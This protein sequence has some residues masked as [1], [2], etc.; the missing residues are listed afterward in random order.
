MRGRPQY[1]SE[2]DGIFHGAVWEVYEAPRDGRI[3]NMLGTNTIV[4]ERL[5]FGVVVK[6]AA[7]S[8]NHRALSSLRDIGDSDQLV[9]CD[10]CGTVLD[11]E[12][13]DVVEPGSWVMGQI[14]HLSQLPTEDRRDL[15]TETQQLGGELFAMPP[16]VSIS[17]A[18]GFTSCVRV[19]YSMVDRLGAQKGDTVLVTAARSN[20]SMTAIQILTQRGATVTA[21]TSSRRNHDH[22]MK[23]GADEVIFSPPNPGGAPLSARVQ[24]KGQAG[25]GFACVLDPFFDLHLSQSVRVLREGGRYI[26]CGSSGQRLRALG[27][28][29]AAHDIELSQS[30]MMAMERRQQLMFDCGDECRDAN[31]ALTDLLAGR[32]AV[33]IDSVWHGPKEAGNFIDRTRNVI[34]RCGKAV[35]CNE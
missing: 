15:Q 18:A 3:A 5:P 12:G 35:Y 31:R 24:E 19:A 11:V 16:D 27:E 9:P 25:G 23:L 17:A 2:L 28:Q 4:R 7:I 32:L 13:E 21:V 26:T 34:E 14:Q 22:I 29:V 1:K 10:F 8:F 33:T 30:L 6:V 20:V